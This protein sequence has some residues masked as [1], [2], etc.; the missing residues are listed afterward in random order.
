MTAN[1][2]STHFVA[3]LKKGELTGKKQT[4]SAVDTVMQSIGTHQRANAN[5]KEAGPPRYKAFPI[6]TNSAVPMTPEIAINWTCLFSSLR[7]VSVEYS[8]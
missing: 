5:N 1:E 4:I 2:S 6:A 8:R 7:R 3:N